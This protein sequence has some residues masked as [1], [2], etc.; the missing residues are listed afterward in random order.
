MRS[1]T[2]KLLGVD[3]SVT[4]CSSVEKLFKSDIRNG[5]LQIYNADVAKMPIDNGQI[6]K[7]FHTNCYYFW[8]DKKAAATEIKRVMKPGALMLTGVDLG[9]LEM[10]ASKG[11]LLYGEWQTEAYMDALKDAG[12]KDIRKETVFVESCGTDITFMYAMKPSPA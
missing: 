1:G 6:D 2:G 3:Y 11:F 10:A 5:K 4:A 9:R 7:V 8:P 12:F